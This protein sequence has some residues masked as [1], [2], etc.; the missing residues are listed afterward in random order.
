MATSLEAPRGV[1]YDLSANNNTGA[2]TPVSV[3]SV[4]FLVPHDPDN[5]YLHQAIGRNAFALPGT[6]QWNFAAEKGFDIKER[7]RFI[8]RAEAQNVFN[9]NDLA[10]GDTDVLDAGAGFLDTSRTAAPAIGSNQ[11]TLVLWGK[12]EF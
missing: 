11:R 9:H 4:H 10:I 3:S 8:I 12:I 1:F 2:L 6:T 5:S 7:A